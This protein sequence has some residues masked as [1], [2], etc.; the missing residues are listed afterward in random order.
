MNN[1]TLTETGINGLVI[2]ESK[3]FGD[4]RG[5]F[6]ESYSRRQFSE[7]GIHQEF[8]QDN[9]S[10]S[11]RG[12]LR[13]LHFQKRFPQGKLVRVV[14]G[15]VFDV[16]VDIRKDSGTFGRWHGLELSAENRKMIYL[17][18]G[19]AHGFLA[20]EDQTEV[21]YKSTDYYHPEDESGIIYNDVEIDIQWPV[22]SG[23]T[24]TISPKDLNLGTFQAYRSKVMA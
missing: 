12:V 14:V 2:L 24:L 3:V 15:S 10:K 11:A 1:Y 8:V 6:M 20:L 21:L 22:L 23:C 19:F 9:H 18:P 4:E 5:F 16:A 13:G 7:H 17:P